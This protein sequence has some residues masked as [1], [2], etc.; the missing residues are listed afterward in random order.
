MQQQTTIVG[1]IIAHNFSGLQELA[2]HLGKPV[3]NTPDEAQQFFVNLRD[4]LP[5]ND[6]EK[7]VMSVHPN[8]LLFNKN[9]CTSMFPKPNENKKFRN[10]CGGY[11]NADGGEANGD[12]D[13]GQRTVYVES[14]SSKMSIPNEFKQGFDFLSDRISEIAQTRNQNQLLQYG[15]VFIVGIIAGKVLFK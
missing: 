7:Y 11:S 1:A 9:I 8:W 10:C 3:P 5:P 13:Y 4:S 6:F 15:M 12:G 2:R 14:A